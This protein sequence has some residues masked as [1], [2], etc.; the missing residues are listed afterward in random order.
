MT[1]ADIISEFGIANTQ[2][3]IGIIFY[4]LDKFEGVMSN[5][6]DELIEK[7]WEEI[8]YNQRGQK[9]DLGVRVQTSGLSDPTYK[10]AVTLIAVEEMVDSGIIPDHVLQFVDDQEETSYQVKNYNRM[11][12]G[13][14]YVERYVRKS[15]GGKD[16]NLVTKYI[17]EDE[18]IID[19]AGNMGVEAATVRQRL[20]RIRLKMQADL[21]GKFERL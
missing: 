8:Q 9:G 10:K 19:I 4:N 16:R 15:L 21:K 13:Y 6:R 20:Y 17:G 5:Y 11:L 7:T 14:K 3:R 2:K 12:K 1:E 18:D